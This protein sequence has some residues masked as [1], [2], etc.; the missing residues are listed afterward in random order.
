[1]EFIIYIVI[2]RVH[3]FMFLDEIHLVAEI[4]Q[5]GAM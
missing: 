3:R 1:M 4:F 2:W 5:S